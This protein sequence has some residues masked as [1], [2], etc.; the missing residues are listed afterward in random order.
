MATNKGADTRTEN[1]GAGSQASNQQ[2]AEQDT[3]AVA[4][5]RAR[6]L[7]RPMTSMIGPFGMIRRLFDDIEQLWG[8]GEPEGSEALERLFM[9]AVDVARRDDKVIVHVDLP[10]MSPEDVDL[11]LTGDALIIEGERHGESEVEE[12]GQWRTER[13]YGEFRRVI[14][15]PDGAD[16]DSAEARFENGVLEVSL[17]APE[18]KRG[19]KLEIN[20]ASEQTK[21]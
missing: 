9:P 21:H 17:R 13:S 18:T 1:G 8:F 20:K 10:G 6:A 2:P 11:T 16:L 5:R 4:P 14:E 3:T 19:R 12:A 7:A 15:L